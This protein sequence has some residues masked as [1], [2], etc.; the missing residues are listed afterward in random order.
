MFFWFIVTLV[1]VTIVYNNH[2]SSRTVILVSAYT[3]QQQQQQQQHH[4]VRDKST[5]NCFSNNINRRDALSDIGSSLI[6]P[7]AAEVMISSPSAASAIMNDPKNRGQGRPDSSTSTSTSRTSDYVLLNDDKKTKFPLVSF[8]LQ[9]YDDETAYKLTLLAL[10]VGYRNFFA[11]VLANNQRGFAKAIRDSQV[12]RSDLFICGSV[13]SNRVQGFDNAKRST[14]EGWKR[15][16]DAFSIGNIDYLDQI[17]LDYPGP[18]A[19]S[20]RGQWSS[21]ID[22]KEQHY[23]QTLAV[24]NFSVKQLQA[25]V[26]TE[27]V[28]LQRFN[29]VVNQLP[30]SVAYHPGNPIVENANFGILVQAWAPLGGSLGGRFDASMKATC[31]RI[32]ESYH[33]SGSQVALRWIIQKGG[34]VCTQT[35]KKEHFVE[36]L[37]IFDFT[38]SDEDMATLDRLA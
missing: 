27:D 8:G 37:N 31:S 35:K 34:S 7:S 30:Y 11:S 29:P 12:P 10:E 4:S 15:N 1:V 14:T 5:T 38:L 26:N 32:G 9:I 18:D 36:D 22:M 16:L 21:F 6:L 23:T 25:I 17:M 13:V 33:K 20:I 28:S 2:D 24:S 3:I 19:E